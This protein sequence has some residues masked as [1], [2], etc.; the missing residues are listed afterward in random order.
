MRV[1]KELN[2]YTLEH[3]NSQAVKHSCLP[4]ELNLLEILF[5]WITARL[6]MC[7]HM[8]MI[9]NQERDSDIISA[10]TDNPVNVHHMTGDACGSL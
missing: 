1:L 2:S 10:F 3:I 7:F 4:S 9:S 5:S 6:N 8:K